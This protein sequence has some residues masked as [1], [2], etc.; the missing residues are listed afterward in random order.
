MRWSLAQPGCV[1]STLTEGKE[2]RVLDYFV[3]VGASDL[4]CGESKCCPRD[5]VGKLFL[6]ALCG[7]DYRC[8]TPENICV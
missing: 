1:R 4:A 7:L 5:P 6:E 8:I 3:L 2:G